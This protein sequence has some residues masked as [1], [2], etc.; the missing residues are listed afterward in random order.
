M[1]VTGQGVLPVMRPR[2]PPPSS[3]SKRLDDIWKCGIFT[4]FGPQVQELEVRLVRLNVA[5]E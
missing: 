5:P 4:N 3:F 2:L 1:K